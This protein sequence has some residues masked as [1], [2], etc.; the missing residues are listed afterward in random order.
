MWAFFSSLRSE[1]E[2]LEN[3]MQALR[4]AV[5]AREE[6]WDKAM[7]REQNYRQQL[8]RLSAETVT[9]RHLSDS[10]HSELEALGVSLMVK[11]Y[12]IYLWSI[13][14]AK[15]LRKN[16]YSFFF[17]R[18]LIKDR[19]FISYHLKEKEAELKA[20]QKDLLSL[21]KIIVKMERRQRSVRESII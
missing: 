18:F 5:V 14:K 11:Q 16:Q 13:S 15:M 3:D 21:K 1:L 17:H 12:F 4:D 7:E 19:Y 2:S 6:A 9:A 20:T 10:R 8:A